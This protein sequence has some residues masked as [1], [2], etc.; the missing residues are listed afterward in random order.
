[1]K[2]LILYF[3]KT[4]HTLE[5]ANATAEGIR[6]A[7]SEVDLNT[8]QDFDSAQ[9]TSYDALIV[10]SPCWAGSVGR[11]ILAKPIDR[12]LTALATDALREMRCGGISVHSGTGGENTIQRIGEMLT[13]KGCTDYRP[14]PAARAGVPLSI[15]KGP[16]VSP[17]DEARFKVYGTAFVT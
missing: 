8:A 9:L 1:M 10:A 11:P 4:G 7:G 3:T 6:S 17:Q 16:S 14:G 2:V 5:A 15:W 12:A 13:Q